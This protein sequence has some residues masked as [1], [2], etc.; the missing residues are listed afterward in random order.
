MS[1][2][3]VIYDVVNVELL[4]EVLLVAFSVELSDSVL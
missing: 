4:K 1:L 2:D 3:V